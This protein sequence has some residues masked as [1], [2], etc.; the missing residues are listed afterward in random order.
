[1][2]DYWNDT[3]AVMAGPAA[4][5]TNVAFISPE[6]F[7]VFSDEP[8]VGR[9]FT[10]EDWSSRATAVVSQAYALSH[11]GASANA[12]GKTVSISQ[13]TFSIVG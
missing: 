9:A 7:P 12:L 11:F 2:A 3:V 1:M 8:A 10:A 6:F 4:E 13:R 5:Y